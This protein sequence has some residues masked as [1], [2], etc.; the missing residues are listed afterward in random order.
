[1][2]PT[3]YTTCIDKKQLHHSSVCFTSR[4][5]ESDLWQIFYFFNIIN[6]LHPVLD[7]ESLI[8]TLR[9]EISLL[10]LRYTL[11]QL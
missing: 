8:L 11:I 10:P 4:E 6:N 1:M 5:T 7:P 3:M 2:L 9:K